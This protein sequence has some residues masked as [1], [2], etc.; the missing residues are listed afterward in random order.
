MKVLNMKNH[1]GRSTHN[2]RNS[3]TGRPMAIGWVILIDILLLGCG[4]VVFALFHHVMPRVIDNS[5]EALPGLTTQTIQTTLPALTTSSLIGES[6]EAVSTTGDRDPGGSSAATENDP[7]PAGST[8]WSRKFAGKFTAGPVE[9]T[10]SSYKSA[11]INVAIKKVKSGDI[12]YYLADIYLSD[13]RYFRTAFAEDQYGR[14]LTEPT[15]S[16]ANRHAAV[17]AING[18]YYGIRSQGIV[19]RNGRL[20]RQTTFQDVL[21]MNHDGSMQ[22]FSANTFKVQDV[23]KNGAWQAWSFGP[24]LL[25]ARGQPMTSFASDVTRANPRSA[26]G[27]Y[28]PGHYCLLLVDGRQPGYSNGI[29]M[30][31]L[32]RLFFELGCKAAYN[33]DGGQSSVLTFLGSVANQ[34]YHS[35]RE[36]SDIVFITDNLEKE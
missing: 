12:T 3:R 16:I 13:L 31:D 23:L 24:M 17:V 8:A 5:G 34:P 14:G 4:L 6:S 2:S 30:I 36:V 7:N 29:S 18:D 25:D 19:I 33:F 26:I 1:F 21:V 11:H 10:A 27:Y 9:K 32:S 28:E 15:L 20:Y 22:T 35:G